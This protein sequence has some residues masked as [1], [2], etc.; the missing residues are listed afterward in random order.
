MGIMDCERRVKYDT[1]DFGLSNWK[2]RVGMI[3]DGEDFGKKRCSGESKDI[4]FGR[5]VEVPVRHP[6][7]DVE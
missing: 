4:R 1:E 5:E 7:G 6:R 2:V 3:S